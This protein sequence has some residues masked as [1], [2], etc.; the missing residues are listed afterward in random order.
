MAASRTCQ[1]QA[2]EVFD[3]ALERTWAAFEDISLIPQYHPV[4]RQVEF[5]SGS[6]RRA[7]GVEYKCIVPAGPRRGWC[8]E[9]VIDHVPLRSSTVAFTADSW[10]LAKLLD[11]FV[12]EIAM[13]P[14]EGTKTRVT[15]RGF[16]TTRGWR[17]WVLNALVIRR[18]MRKRANDTIRGLKRLLEGRTSSQGGAALSSERFPA[19]HAPPR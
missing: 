17:G 11:D 9:K 6:R 18:T 13:E 8:I 15:L 19:T 16:Y 4:V 10:G 1:W 2:E 12:T 5:P 7:P 3:A 14:V